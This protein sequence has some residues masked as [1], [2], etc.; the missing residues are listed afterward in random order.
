VGPFSGRTWFVRMNAKNRGMNAEGTLL[1]DPT[2]SN[3]I[4]S[5][6]T[7]EGHW[8]VLRV[9]GAAARGLGWWAASGLMVTAGFL[10][11]ELVIAH[12]GNRLAV[13]ICLALAISGILLAL[14]LWRR[15]RGSD[16]A[17][18]AVVLS[19]AFWASLWIMFWRSLPR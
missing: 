1:Q 18:A 7:A 2:G 5:T 17:V 19:C 3:P 4:E 15:R 14:L 12:K 10:A 11:F 6:P 16:G 9:L 13:E 8:T